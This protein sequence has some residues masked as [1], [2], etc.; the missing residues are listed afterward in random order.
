[1]DKIYSKEVLDLADKHGISHEDLP[2]II[3]GCSGGLS[4]IYKLALGQAPSCE[5]C[6]NAHDLRYFIGKVEGTRKQADQKLRDS[7][8]AIGYFPDGWKGTVRKVWR[9]FR[10]WVMYIAVRLFGKN[11]WSTY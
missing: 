9:W 10:A 3:D 1:M 6:C 5:Q 4:W 8:K 2:I 7:S 11:H